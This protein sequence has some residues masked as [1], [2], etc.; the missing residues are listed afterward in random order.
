[1]RHPYL[2][3]L[4]F[5]LLF[6]GCGFL[7]TGAYA[8]ST[9]S[10]SG[11]VT[12]EKK[13]GI[14]GATV[15]VDGTS[16][17]S[18]T[19][20]DGTFSLQN[21][22][23]GTQT[24]VISFVGYNT[25][26]RPVTVVAG[27]TATIDASISENTTQLSE[28]VVIGYGTQRR[29]DVTGSVEQIT[30]KQFV[31]G[32]VTNPEQLIQGKVAGVQITTGGGAPGTG[33]QILIRGGSSLNASNQ[34]L[35]VIDGVPVDNTGIAGASNPLS[36]INPNDIESVT[37]LKD[38]S[39]TAIY[40]VRASNGVILV[41]T[42]RGLAGEG[43]RVNVSTQNSIAT[44][45]KYSPVLTGDEYRTLVNTYGNAQQKG[46]LGTANTDWQKEIYRNAFTTD[47]NVSVL[48]S[49]GVIPFRVSAGYLNQQGLL[50]NND[51][52][53]Y[54]GSIGLTPVLL[55]GNLRV[56]VNVKATQI[57]NNFGS[58]GAVNTAVVFDPTQEIT[59]TDA[60][61]APY[62]GYVES[63]GTD[64]Q[65]NSLAP[66]NP[67]G[68]I[69][70]RDD[71]STVRRSIGNVQLD[72]KLPFVSGLSANVNLGYDVQRG[73][74]TTFVPSTAASDFNHGGVN[75]QYKQDLNNLILEAY[76][77]Y[78]HELFGQRFDI[79]AGY[80]FQKF[81][82]RGYL[83]NDNRADGSVF[84]PFTP[85]YD[86]RDQTLTNRVLL[87]YYSRANLNI[88]D[89]YL[90]TGTFR[91]DQTSNFAKG[92]RTGYFP[93]G[94]VAWRVKGEDFLKNSSAVS[95]L[96][97]R[98]GVGQ[99]GQQDIGANFGFLPVSTLS[100]NTSQVQFGTDAAGNPL[101]L[102][103]LRP[104]FY[105]PNLTWETTTTYNLGL[106]YGFLK[107]R[108]YGSVEVYQRDTKD[109]LFFSNV[110][111]GSNLTNAGFLN[112]GSLTNKGL[113]FSLNTDVVRTTKLG[114]T[115]NA[116]ATFNQNRITK[117]TIVDDPKYIGQETGGIA[118]G[119]GNNVQINSVGYEAGSFYVYNQLYNANG[120][121]IQNAVADLNMD[122]I[123][124]GSD[125]YRFKSAR[126][127]AILGLGATTTYGKA[128]LAFT[129]RSNLGQYAYN[130]VRSSATFNQNSLNYLYN[131]S[132]EQ[133]ES[134]FTTGQNQVLLSNYFL[135]NAS[136]L[137]MENVT[138]GYN[139]GSVAGEKSSL[140]L[141]FAVQNLFVVTN[142]KGLD[143]EVGS[144]IDNTIYP[145]PRT[146]TVGLN[147]GF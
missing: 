83:F 97:L 47:N 96:K 82:N 113:E 75:N 32:Q 44:V 37:V 91:I 98:F 124:N 2:A 126:P 8:Q 67:V 68:L 109:L 116:N 142:Y 76:G 13:E 144:G 70:T 89:R 18:S 114:V 51:L 42:K 99:T 21:V 145:R 16:L 111:A 105:N 125:R 12:D 135:E 25:V 84:T 50:K 1:M 78:Q 26:R 134:R 137:R 79:L 14:P 101:F 59:S 4:L 88:K 9:G 23:A 27:Q 118:G 73:E 17:G 128:S 65:L 92:K 139:F 39:S 112:V 56:D 15:L 120:Q 7:P 140:G 121:P 132:R 62:G 63:L 102:Q 41:T 106:D 107:G 146:Y 110:S 103:T 60:R 48:G 38:A 57:H 77:K 61:Y 11:R 141:T 52:Q 86:N 123:I 130:N 31:K 6:L 72:Y 24:L 58:Q 55:D 64:G 115:L 30:E 10:I 5:L 35:I 53:R 133:L 71:Q 90:F 49:A 100:N 29:Q 3:K 34:P 104:G 93:S 85:T 69:N 138:L 19:N 136:F 94:A 147:F 28:A 95:D 81:Q 131:V 33:T 66:R 87:S 127:Q 108:V 20:V 119:V 22:P 80:S 143:P 129:M 45:A 74:G 43:I 122:G 40:G 54:S 36:L 117:L 46:L